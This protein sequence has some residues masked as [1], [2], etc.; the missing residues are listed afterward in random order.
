MAFMTPRRRFIE[1]LTFGKPDRVP[2]S[3]GWPRESTLTAWRTQGLPAE[4][5]WWA[6]FLNVLGIE[7]EKTRPQVDLGVDFRLIPPFEEKVLA[8]V[9]GH[10]IVQDWKGNVCEIS[11]RYD[12]SYLRQAKDFV[13]RRWLRCPVANR[14]DWEA[15]KTRYDPA[16]PGRFPAD[17]ED[18]CARVRDRD[19]AL[20]VSFSGPF[21]QM[22]EWCGF[23]GLCLL[24]IDDPELVDEMAAF[25]TDFV[26]TV[27]GRV[28]R[29]AVPDRVHMSEDMAYKAHAM[30][31]PA[32]VRRFCMPGYRRWSEQARAT[33]VPLV[34]MDSDGCV[35]ELLPLW[36][37]SGI[38][39]CDPMEVAAHNDLPAY[40]RRFGRA[41]AYE[42]GVDKR[43]MARG[44]AVLRGELSRLAPVVR[45]GG[46]IPGCDYGVPPD[47]SWPHFVEYGRELA[48]LTGWL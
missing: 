38:N 4:G 42:G 14:Q 45:D 17:F 43:A 29:Q 31:S 5:D 1:A 28:L 24:V 33:G 30:I 22:R 32:M 46:Y 19:W 27:L 35:D 23:E 10:T 9:D 44:G 48:H 8:H 26:A 36:I 16:A 12:V 20:T 21:W 13:T 39:L 18:R 2:F 47:V 7:R 11:D 3:P 15:M 41:M 6:C 34:G 25:W 40:R 37:E